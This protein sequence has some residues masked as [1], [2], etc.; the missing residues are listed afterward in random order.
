M[1]LDG[2]QDALV[3]AVAAANPRTVVVLQT[4]GPVLMP[5]AGKVAAIVEAWYPGRAGGEAIANVLTGR[6]NPSGHLPVTFPRSLDQLP[7]PGEPREG[8][9]VYQEGAAVGYKWFDREGHAPLFA[10][11]HGL[12]YTRFAFDHL[13]A[14]RDG[15]GLVAIVEVSNQGERPGADVVQLYVEGPGWEAPRRLA[16]FA[17]VEL[18]A[19]ETRRV[20][21]PVDPRLLATWFM[22]RPGWTHPAG[23]YTVSVGHSS[24]ELVQS[25]VVEL[26]PSYLPPDW[27][28]AR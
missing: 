16:G 26:P 6:I 20:E 28:P 4:G 12:S 22:G 9:V 18:A 15:D 23:A 10:F 13:V 11:G 8:D 1:K 2:E 27:K 14:T 3:D 21:I 7:W 5:W 24:R 17:R 25:V 19:G